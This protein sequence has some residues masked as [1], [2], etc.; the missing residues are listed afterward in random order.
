ML[1]S[2]G[3]GRRPAAEEPIR[4]V[5]RDRGMLGRDDDMCDGEI[6][7]SAAVIRLFEKAGWAHDVRWPTA[8]RLA[9]L[10]ARTEPAAGA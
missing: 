2:P 6:D 4:V 10:A 1:R 3:A 7:I 5:V 9:R 8:K